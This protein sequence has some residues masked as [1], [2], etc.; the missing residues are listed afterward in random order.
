MSHGADFLVCQN[1]QASMFPPFFHWHNNNERGRSGINS[2]VL[3]YSQ[4]VLWLK[5]KG[6]LH[7]M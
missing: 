5:Q 2:Y 1:N 3:N 4:E 6:C 7:H